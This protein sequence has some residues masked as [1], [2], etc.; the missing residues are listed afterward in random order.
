MATLTQFARIALCGHTNWMKI[1][2]IFNRELLFKHWRF[3]LL[4]SALLCQIAMPDFACK[5]LASGIE[6]RPPLPT[7]GYEALEPNVRKPNSV[8]KAR[9]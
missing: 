7:A 6:T 9:K 2:F 3:I 4:L 8:S 1:E 5:K